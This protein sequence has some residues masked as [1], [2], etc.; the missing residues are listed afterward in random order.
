M[1]L[2]D[3]RGFLLLE[4][5]FATALVAIGLFAIMEGLNRC[6]AA[7]RS[8]NNYAIVQNLLA[9]KTYEFRVERPSDFLDQE[10]RFEDYPGYT[11]SRT[12]EEVDPEKQ[13][14]WKQTITVFWWERSKLTSDSL[15]E[16]KYLPQKQR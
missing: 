14:L 4:V 8:V 2:R 5:I 9:N 7:A 1:R 16:Y 3:Q 13:G 15:V 6:L 11:W 10:G 12:L